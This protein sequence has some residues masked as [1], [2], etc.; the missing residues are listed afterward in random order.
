MSSSESETDYDYSKPHLS[1]N[2]IEKII[3]MRPINL[4]YY[5][6]AFVH[7]SIQKYTKNSNSALN[8]TKHSYERYEYL[9][10]SVLSLIIAKYLF[11]KYKDKNEGFLTRIRTKLVNGKTLAKF[12]KSLDLGQYILMSSNVEKIDGRNNDRILEDIFEALICAIYMDL[13]FSKTENFVIS[14][15]ERFI[16][17][18]ELEEDDNYKDILLRFCQTKMRTTPTYDVV[19]MTGPPHKR[20]FKVSCYIQNIEYKNGEGKCKKIAEQLSAKETLKYFGHVFN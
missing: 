1:R 19:G 7:K 11:N 13:G 16:D 5:Y 8:Y 15:I 9:G 3:N 10:D 4:E 20:V 2:H 12:A 17:F 14:V 18:N 6:Q